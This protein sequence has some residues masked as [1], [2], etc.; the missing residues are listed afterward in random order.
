MARTKNQLETAQV[1]LATTPI[2]VGYLKELVR[3]GL[4]GKNP[5]DAAE[6]LLSTTIEQMVRAGHVKNLTKRK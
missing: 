2:V 5:S 6:R 4:Y 3:T 1:T